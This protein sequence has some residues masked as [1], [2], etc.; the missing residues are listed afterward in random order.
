LTI[1][2]L[3]TKGLLLWMDPQLLKERILLLKLPVEFYLNYRSSYT[4]FVN[5]NI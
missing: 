2:N 3:P 5:L 4:L 1:E